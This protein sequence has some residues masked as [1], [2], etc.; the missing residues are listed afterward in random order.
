MASIRSKANSDQQEVLDYLTNSPGPL[1]F[2]HGKAGSGKSYLINRLK[3]RVNGCQVVAP[4]NMACSV[5]SLGGARTIHSFFYGG[6]DDFENAFQNPANAA[7][8]AGR[9]YSHTSR[10]IR[11]LKMLVIDEISMVRA[12]LLEMINAIC[13]EIRE[14]DEPFGGI[15]T[16]FVG[17]LFQLPPIVADEAVETYLREEYGGAYF[18][19][20]HVVHDNLHLI[21]YF[22]LSKSY[23]QKS[24][25]AFVSLLDSFR[26]PLSSEEKV[27]L[28]KRI[29]QR[30]TPVDQIPKDAKIVASSNA[31]VNKVNAE[32]LAALNQDAPVELEAKFEIRLRNSKKYAILQPSSLPT[33]LDIE[34]IVVPTP[35]DAVFSFKPGAQVVFTVNGKG[36][37]KPFVNGDVGTI[38]DFHNETFRI[39]VPRTK[40]EVTLRKE[41]RKRFEITYDEKLQQPSKAQEHIQTTWQYPLKLAYAITIHKA[42]GQSYPRVVLDLAS[43]IFAPGQLYVALS[44]AQSLSGLYLT[45]P[46]AYTDIIADPEIFEF[47]SI[48]RK[49]NRSSQ[50]NVSH[51][52][53]QQNQQ[54]QQNNSKQTTSSSNSSSSSLPRRPLNELLD[55][56]EAFVRV[57]EG[58]LPTQT[59]MLRVLEGYRDL[60]D[61]SQFDL[62]HEELV[63]IAVVISR[64]YQLN[65]TYQGLFNIV[66]AP[67]REAQDCRYALNA[68]FE[69]Y[70]DVI[71]FPRVQIITEHYN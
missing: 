57:Q 38:I 24:D 70:T 12:D 33:T 66:S 58:D 2:V 37:P 71:R 42:Q 11:N 28:V 6:V 17:D 15:A 8:N 46:V 25:P 35:F 36:N 52:H 23:R 34:P 64:S 9:I 67:T 45:K 31:Q 51:Q 56:F 47:L 5:Y 32:R 18:F 22:E 4:T 43:H 3:E 48:L 63:K 39:W 44:R 53:N 49:S 13:Q 41:E 54:N 26:H 30:V 21:R 20:S 60:F 59:Y 19:N 29:N 40:Q 68:I 55:T 61:R 69:I 65:D 10:S 27:D 16:V 14:N 62:A 7:S 1:T 50:A